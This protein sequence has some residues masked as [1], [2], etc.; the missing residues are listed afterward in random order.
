LEKAAKVKF[1]ADE[2]RRRVKRVQKEASV[3]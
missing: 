1:F 2:L 3:V